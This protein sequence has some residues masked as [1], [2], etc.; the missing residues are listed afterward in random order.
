MKKVVTVAF[1]SGTLLFLVL[2]SACS[3][4]NTSHS[5]DAQI[6]SD[7]QSE[8][9]ISTSAVK[10]SD[11][12]VS[13]KDIVDDTVDAESGAYCLADLDGF[14]PFDFFKPRVPCASPEHIKGI[15]VDVTQASQL[16]LFGP[17]DQGRVTN[18]FLTGM[19]P[20]H[21]A[22]IFL[23]LDGDAYPEIIE[24][25][26]SCS[27]GI[28]APRVLKYDLE[29]GVLNAFTMNLPHDRPMAF[30][31]LDNDGEPEIIMGRGKPAILWGPLSASS[32]YKTVDGDTVSPICAGVH[33][34]Q[35][36]DYDSDGFLDLLVSLATCESAVE[37]GP[38]VRLYLNQGNRVFADRSEDLLEGT[39]DS[40]GY[41]AYMT[42]FGSTRRMLVTAPLPCGSYGSLGFFESLGLNDEGYPIFSDLDPTPR[43]EGFRLTVPEHEQDMPLWY[44]I[45]MGMV[46]GDINNDGLLDMIVALHPFHSLFLAEEGDVLRDRTLDLSFAWIPV[47]ESERYQFA[48]GMAL[49]DLDQDGHQDFLAAHGDDFLPFE[50]G[51]EKSIGPQMLT[52]HWNGGSLAFEDISERIGLGALGNYRGL[53]YGDLDLDG[54]PDLLLGGKGIP[55]RLL[56]N[57]LEHPNKGFSIRLVG[58]N[59]NPSAMGAEVFVEV[60]PGDAEQR[61]L[62]GSQA[63]PNTTSEGLVFVGLGAADKAETV[64][65][66]WPSGFESQHKE[67]SAGSLH[68][69]VEPTLF[70]ITPLNRHSPADG[71][72]QVEVRVRPRSADGTILADADAGLE[73][74]HGA[75]SVLEP[76]KEADGSYLFRVQAPNEPGSTRLSVTVD[77]VELKVFPR[78]WWD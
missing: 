15:F 76:V 50:A 56:R 32:S 43:D 65:V 46:S 28:P 22:A 44:F 39:A 20:E 73:I 61:F 47:P 29:N 13:A 42:T 77:G 78:I 30:G 53:S 55:P 23:D 68:T 64:R 74:T 70:E 4:G 18:D 60:S 1:V 27:S 58:T 40:A 41:T 12:D 14:P 54:D 49:L 16:P 34:I 67:L 11:G 36:V 2:I 48:W 21:T 17:I 24:Y 7:Q 31:D 8:V 37:P 6:S 57:D 25:G 19:E 52:A 59:S 10:D 71:V 51:H 62:V 3:S 69:L 35:L 33:G 26:V 63:S 5:E 45:P 38:S 66:L 75:G 9:E 72:S